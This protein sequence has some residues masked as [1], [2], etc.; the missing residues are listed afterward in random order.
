[1]TACFIERGRRAALLPVALLLLVIAAAGAAAQQVG[2]PK[3]LGPPM[4][5][6]PAVAPA[7]SPPIAAPAP[8]A[9]DG[10]SS[11]V[12]DVKPLDASGLDGIGPLDEGNGGL[13]PDLWRNSDRTT[14]EKLLPTLALP[15]NSPVLRS[16]A[17]RLLLSAAAPPKGSGN[18]RSFIIERAEALIGLGDVD[19]A[20]VLLKLLPDKEVDAVALRLMADLAWLADDVAG[21]CGIAERGLARFEHEPYF[22]RATIFCQAQAGQRDKAMLGLDMLRDQ[23]QADDPQFASL[24]D[25][26]TGGPPAKVG[27]A[28]A[29]MPLHLAML[30]AAK[31]ELPSDTASAAP[32]AVIAALIKD[33]GT[34]AA[35]RLTLAER[36]AAA[37]LLDAAVLAKLY[38]AEPVKPAELDDMIKA[39]QPA[40]SPHAR[41]VLYQATERAGDPATWARLVQRALRQARSDGTYPL[42]ARLY[43]P[44]LKDLAVGPASP[45]FALEAA[46][47]L[48]VT[49][50]HE[51]A[52]GWIAQLKAAGADAKSTADRVWLVQR[53]GG[54]ATP[55]D[56]DGLA[57]WYAAAKARDAAVGDAQLIRMLALFDGLGGAADRLWATLVG[58]SA[59]ATMPPTD[60]VLWYALDAASVDRRSGETILLTLIALGEPVV[61]Q[62]GPLAIGR[63]L[64]ALK[65]VGRGA[66]ARD[67][68]YEIALANGL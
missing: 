32:L 42:V 65:R 44:F 23:S 30:R 25:Q 61:G 20:A 39:D 53:L 16:L 62:A 54:A 63:G 2:P 6:G 31:L 29:L 46:I 28:A 27:S 18:G 50:Y 5:L 37:G 33:E 12:V 56:A 45:S 48:H 38:A 49:G 51:K 13:G 4:Q 1:M 34:P 22:A 55:A 59:A 41:A 47:A 21:G 3:P 64:N 8:P 43:L 15:E 10:S 36:A 67:L 9:T 35:L 68:A 7:P 14:I 19:G 11:L 57:A 40:A 60:P 24:I 58:S 17:R 52:A 26:L 66:E